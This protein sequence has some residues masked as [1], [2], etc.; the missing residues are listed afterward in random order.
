[1]NIFSLLI[2]IAIIM[3][4]TLIHEMGHFLLAR[5]LSI[6]VSDFSI[7]FGPNLFVYEDKKKTKW[8]INLIP[9]GGYIAMANN[10]NEI[11]A[12]LDISPLKRFLIALGGP[13]FNILFFLFGGTIF[14]SFM[15][16]K[17][18]NY[19]Y[20]Q[21]NYYVINE[22]FILNKD[23]K[24]IKNENNFKIIEKGRIINNDY[25]HKMNF[26][27]SFFYCLETIKNLFIRIFKIFSSWKEIK[28]LRSIISSHKSFNENLNKTNNTFNYLFMYMI[29]LSL[30][31]GIFN[32]LPF[33]GLDGFWILFSIIHI[34]LKKTNRN[35]QRKLIIVLSYLSWLV[36]AGFLFF[37]FRDIFFLIK[38]IYETQ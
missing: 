3:F 19:I 38:D 32:L 25:Y 12:M 16:L 1:M 14:F 30:N 10:G 31:L 8:S 23:F 17:T 13:L 37:I 20:N 24:E 5:Y 27:K 21:Q 18:T 7:G 11:D 15:G 26:I 9:L 6:P 2:F 34:F 35:F 4:L 28:E 36:F 22:K 33:F 29:M